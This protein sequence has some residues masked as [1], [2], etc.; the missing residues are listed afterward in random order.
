ML[1]ATRQAAILRRVRADGE[2]SVQELADIL[3]VSPSTVRRDLNTLSAQGALRRVRGGGSAVGEDPLPFDVVAKSGG[4]ERET[5]ARAA[6]AMVPEGAVVALDM[7]TTTARV[8][9]KLR[10]RA[11]TVITASIA[12]VQELATCEQPEVVVLGGVLRRSYRSLV[13]T[14][15]TDA[16]AGLRADLCFISMSGIRPTGQVMDDTGIEVPVKRALINSADRAV[17]LATSSKFPGTGIA[18]VAEAAAISTLITT[19][20]AHEPTLAA[21][22]QAGTEVIIL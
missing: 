4:I 16:L 17:L 12:A 7:G 3:D 19:G 22:R 14:L 20:G 11:L 21:F 5:I 2:V 9:H 6:A 15:T 13:G 10:G 1:T 8:A 18:V